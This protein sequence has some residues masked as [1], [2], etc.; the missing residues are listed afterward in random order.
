MK[1]VIDGKVYDTETADCVAGRDSGLPV[2]D[3][4]WFEESLYVSQKG[5][6][7]AHGKGGAM[8]HYSRS[9]G[10]NQWGGGEALRPMTDNDALRWLEREGETDAILSRFPEQVEEA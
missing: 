5:R 1:R 3:F 10:Q 6:W 7:F 9:T 8:S 2:N 4:G